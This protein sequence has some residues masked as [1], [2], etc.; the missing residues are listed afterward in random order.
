[1]LTNSRKEVLTLAKVKAN[2]TSNSTRKKRRPPLSPEARENQMISYAMD[3]VEQR[4]LDG[5]ASSQETTHFLK[6]GSMKNRL[7]MEKLQEENKLIKAKVENLKSQA[8]QEEL[9]E[10]AINA[11]RSYAGQGG[12][13]E[14]EEWDD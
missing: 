4:L 10:K 14:D 3:L 5:S 13:I 11:M 8:R 7:E 2:S 12:E 9:F 1:M 6:L